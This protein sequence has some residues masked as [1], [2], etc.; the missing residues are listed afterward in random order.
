MTNTSYTAPAARSTLA[1]P[2]LSVSQATGN[3]VRM[4]ITYVLLTIGAIIM[5]FPMLWMLGASLKPE[6]QILTQPLAF[7]SEWVH[8]RA[9]TS[10]QEF[11]LWSVTGT[12]GANHE[13]NAN[14]TRL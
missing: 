7:P 2:R 11:P 4:A 8:E 12:D 3:R 6:W 1:A 13:V 9:G 10:T 5:I 14:A